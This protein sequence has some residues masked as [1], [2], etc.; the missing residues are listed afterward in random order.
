[1]RLLSLLG[2]IRKMFA[3][4]KCFHS[5]PVQVLDTTLG[6]ASTLLTGMY[7]SQILLGPNRGTSL[8]TSTRPPSLVALTELVLISV[9]LLSLFLTG[10]APG[11]H[12]DQPG[13]SEGPPMLVISGSSTISG[14]LLIDQEMPTPRPSTSEPTASLASTY[15]D[16]LIT[17]SREEAVK[18]RVRRVMGWLEFVRSRVVL[19][20]LQSGEQRFLS[21][22]LARSESEL[23]EQPVG[24]LDPSFSRLE[25]DLW[26]ELL[27]N[28][29]VDSALSAQDLGLLK[30]R[31]DK[32]ALALARA[33]KPD[34]IQELDY[35]MVA[36][37]STDG[38]E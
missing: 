4:E 7:N 36:A 14:D 24:A 26:R 34:D 33:E 9:F 29:E 28:L 23:S 16:R 25:F 15:R 19:P 10:C 31:L 17:F 3:E 8:E 30:L 2:G 38:Y 20:R 37:R 12:Q 1:M 27:T 13:R 35:L 5:E 18:A 22:T 11:L 21:G 6:K 32:A